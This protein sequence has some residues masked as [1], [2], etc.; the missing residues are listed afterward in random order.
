[1]SFYQEIFSEANF[2]PTALL[3]IAMV[4]WV[5]MIFGVVGMDMFDID[6]DVDA[7]VGVDLDVDIDVDTS[8]TTAAGSPEVDI[9]SG[10]SSTAA[11]AA[12][13][14]LRGLIEFFYLSEV[15]V[16]MVGTTF[17]I[18]YWASN[19]VLNHLFNPSQAF[20][21]SV[22][23]VIPNIVIA[24]V[25]TRVV[26][27]P[28]A[29][30]LKKTAPED[31][32]R[33]NMVGQTGTVTTSE[34]NENFG[35]IEIKP[36][37]EPEHTFNARTAPGQILSKGDSVTIISYNHEQNTFLVELTKRENTTNE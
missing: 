35:Q 4:Y 19:F 25:C 13:G 12:N 30:V 20:L 33:S 21:Y 3:I 18:V 16:A 23:W 6:V 26:M 7:D 17:L 27:A 10:G 11:A 31:Y 1:M 22:M 32:S 36:Q 34:L 9:D 8:A 28:M 15:P 37:D 2:L 14:L 5:M 29:K 24:A